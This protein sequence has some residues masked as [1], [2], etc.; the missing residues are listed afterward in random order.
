MCRL[1]TAPGY[2]GGVLR[3]LSTSDQQT[4]GQ[5][6]AGVYPRPPSQQVSQIVWHWLHCSLPRISM[7][8]PPHTGQ[9]GRQA[10]AAGASADVH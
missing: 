9:A 3:L 10:A 6:R 1:L 5:V 7:S 2:A 4:V 8:R